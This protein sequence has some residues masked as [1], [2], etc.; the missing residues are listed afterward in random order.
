MIVLAHLSAWMCR[1]VA[2]SFYAQVVL[3]FSDFSVTR[4][5]VC[6]NW[7]VP[8]VTQWR[9]LAAAFARASTWR[10]NQPLFLPIWAIRKDDFVHFLEFLLR[11]LLSKQ[12]EGLKEIEKD[13]WQ[14]DAQRR[15]LQSSWPCVKDFGMARAQ[16]SCWLPKLVLF[17]PQHGQRS[18]AMLSR[19]I[20]MASRSWWLK[21]FFNCEQSCTTYHYMLIVWPR[22][23]KSL[24]PGNRR[25]SSR[26][27][28]AEVPTSRLWGRW[29]WYVT[30]LNLTPD[31][32]MC[33]W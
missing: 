20:A 31:I 29:A 19:Y 11:S 8:L 3:L 25:P 14:Q 18:Y 17:H 21:T 12:A 16:A 13:A 27:Q 5:I 32:L 22:V 26:E 28:T 4:W 24:T 23:W 2:S 30:E 1:F 9:D 6:K 10:E 7:W 15:R 33:R